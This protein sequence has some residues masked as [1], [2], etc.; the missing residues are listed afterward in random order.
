MLLSIIVPIYNAELYLEKCLSSLLC[1][2]LKED[3][4]EI[5]LINDGSTDSSPI[6]CQQFIASHSNIR[7]V[8]QTNKGLGEA[9]NTGLQEACGDYLCFVDS[10]DWLME[11]GLSGVVRY[12]DGQ[13]DLIRFYSNVVFDNTHIIKKADEGS[14]VFK[15]SGLD[16]IL[17]YGF[18]SFCWNY[19]YR[20]SFLLDNRI[21]FD[22]V[23]CEDFRFIAHILLDD[24]KIISTSHRIYEHLYRTG[25]LSTEINVKHNRQMSC[26][27]LETLL[28]LSR[29]LQLMKQPIRDQGLSSLQ[30]NVVFLFLRLFRSDFSKDEYLGL[31]QALHSA[32]LLPIQRP[33]GRPKGL[34]AIINATDIFPCLFVVVRWVYLHIYFPFVKSWYDQK[35]QV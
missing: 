13:K 33:L 2:G 18:D 22:P 31:R 19:L 1:Q 17:R 4:Y 32:K 27:L 34:L 12:C 23:L 7:M 26:D 29:R 10:D 9:R 28:G 11:G 20:R 35:A 30:K 14:V 8:S 6:L 3:D 24:P 15:G 5:I 21:F 25:T 16:F